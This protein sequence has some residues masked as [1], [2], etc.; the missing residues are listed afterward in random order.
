MF[1]ANAELQPGAGIAPTLGGEISD[2]ISPNIWRDTA[3]STSWKVTHNG[4]G[5][6]LGADLDQ[7]V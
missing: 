2:R 7:A 4:R 1:T 3:T 6:H 5:S